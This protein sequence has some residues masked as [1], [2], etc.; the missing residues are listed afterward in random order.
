M[1]IWRFSVTFQK[2][3]KF[4]RKLGVSFTNAQMFTSR[5]W[6]ACTCFSYYKS[7]FICI[8][9]PVPPITIFSCIG[10]SLPLHQQIK[11][12]LGLLLGGTL[13]QRFLFSSN[14]YTSLSYRSWS[15]A[16]NVCFCR[17]TLSLKLICMWTKL[18]H[19]D[20]PGCNFP[21]I[22][23]FPLFHLVFLTETYYIF[24]VQFLCDFFFT[25]ISK[26]Y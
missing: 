18:N 24:F 23:V 7:R 14:F 8:L 5:S 12:L 17:I 3:L 11:A 16:F 13:A 4:R 26:P 2:T 20:L 25:F 15:V 6:W 1:I 10:N 9:L 19:V 21:N 22:F